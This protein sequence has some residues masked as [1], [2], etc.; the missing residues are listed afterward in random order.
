ME[1]NLKSPNWYSSSVIHRLSESKFIFCS[2]SSLF[3]YTIDDLDGIQ[4]GISFKVFDS[5][6]TLVTVLEDSIIAC[7][8]ENGNGSLSLNLY[9]FQSLKPLNSSSDLN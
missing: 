8:S 5:K 1:I 4:K 6:C 9:G 7:A 3:C 2:R